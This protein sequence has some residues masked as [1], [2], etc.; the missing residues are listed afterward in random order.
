MSPQPT[1][2]DVPP[3]QFEAQVLGAPPDVTVVVDFWAEWCAPCRALGPVLEKVVAGYGGRVVLAKV[4]I[5]QDREL[6]M[7]FG[8]QS[9]PS[10][11]IFR[12]GRVVGEFMGALPEPDVARVIAAAVPSP[13]DELVAEGDRLLQS[14]QV[15]QAAERYARALAEDEHHA[16]ALL[17]LG[18]AAAEQGEAEKAR[19]L[20]ERIGEDATE[21]EAAQ[22]VLARFGF[23][24]NCRRRG[25]EE[26][27]RKALEEQP[28]D[29]D[30][31]Y[32]LAC[33]L[34]VKG[35]YAGALD[36]LLA[37]LSADKNHGDGAAREAVLRIFALVGTRSELANKYRR[38]LAA[39][40]Y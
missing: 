3:G 14:G 40:L 37:V 15:D 39:V 17:R 27:C 10:V 11:K 9:I 38:K 7:Q 35:D 30:A 32:D 24:A 16:G 5:D 31:R 26:A 33:C 2:F 23:E 22:V 6:A 36:E 12:A 8:I 21:Y 20:L 18:T 29:L 19:S 25:G 13:A 34:V 1:V 4:N 28:D